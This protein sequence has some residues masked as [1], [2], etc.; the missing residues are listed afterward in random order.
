MAL[1]T[2]YKV[3]CKDLY[4]DH[5]YICLYEFSKVWIPRFLYS[6]ISQK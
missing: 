6:K 2:G 5:V 1:E 4:Q 3:T